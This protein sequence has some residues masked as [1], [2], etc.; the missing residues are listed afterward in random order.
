VNPKIG[1]LES[2]TLHQVEKE[3]LAFN[4]AAGR[5]TSAGVS[6]ELLESRRLFSANFSESEPNDLRSRADV[7]ERPSDNH[8]L[9][10]G[11]VNRFGDRDWFKVQL[12]QGDVVGAALS[13]HDGLDTVLRLVNSAGKLMMGNDDGA[14]GGLPADSPLPTSEAATD[15]AIYYVINKP[16]TY[17]L[18]VSAFED[19]GTGNY[20]MELLVARPG[21]EAKPRGARQ[22]L[23]LDFDGAKIDFNR[24][25]FSDPGKQTFGPLADALPDWGLTAADEDAVIDAIISVVT[26]KLSTFVSANGANENF[27]ID[28]RNSRDHRDEFGKNPLVSRVAVGTIGP[29]WP[30]FVGTA[31]HIDVGNFKTDDEAAAAV[32]WFAGALTRI[33]IDPSLT[34]TDV[35]GIAFGTVIAHEMGHLLGCYHTDLPSLFEGKPN[36]MDGD[37]APTLGPDFIAGTKDDIDHQLGVDAFASDEQF[38]GVNDT[39]TTVAFALSVGKS[40]PGSAPDSAIFPPPRS[41]LGKPIALASK[42]EAMEGEEEVLSVV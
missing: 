28:I 2:R 18:E 29:D 3:L 5:R 10:S 34:V 39:L 16:G 1:C 30:D 11:R 24:Y 15:S 22:I 27:G 12:D 21:M 9:I 4:V 14:G 31:Q 26:D 37:I 20:N 7:I 25:G 36:L 41:G 17:Y 42:W 38:E 6:V 32:D 35:A 8:V 19:A 40:A 23:F 33:G 13:G